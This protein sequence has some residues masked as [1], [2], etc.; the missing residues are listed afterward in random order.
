MLILV[1]EFDR[2]RFPGKVLVAD[3]AR[4]TLDRRRAHPG[5]ARIRGRRVRPATDRYAS[6]GELETDTSHPKRV[7]Q[8][9]R[10]SDQVARST[11]RR[12]EGQ[13]RVRSAHIIKLNFGTLSLNCEPASHDRNSRVRAIRSDTKSALLGE[14]TLGIL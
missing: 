6:R 7:A 4:E 8:L 3:G 14:L 2:Q 1:T 9:I 5:R 10:S 11:E 13:Q 12:A